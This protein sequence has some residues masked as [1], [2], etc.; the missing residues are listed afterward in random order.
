MIDA[1]PFLA[2]NVTETINSETSVFFSSEQTYDLMACLHELQSEK[3]SLKPKVKNLLE[4][5]EIELRRRLSSNL[6]VSLMLE[7][8]ISCQM[9]SALSIPAF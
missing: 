6:A 7:N 3:E 5:Y 4:E 9:K 2:E 1:L 8:D